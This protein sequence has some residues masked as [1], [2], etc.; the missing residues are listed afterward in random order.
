MHKKNNI[1]SNKIIQGLR[2]LANTLPRG[3]KTVF[4]KSGHNFQSIIE[5]WERFLPKNIKNFCYPG[6]INVDKTLSN[7]KLIIY[8]ERGKELEVEYEKINIKDRINSYFGY[9][10]IKEIKLNNLHKKLI[11]EK[12]EKNKKNKKTPQSFFK[13]KDSDLKTSIEKLISA[14]EKKNN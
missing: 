14:Y 7:G 6:K 5:N 1:R 8:V 10:F 13:I 9:N 12:K 11:I 2:P 3:L 4:K